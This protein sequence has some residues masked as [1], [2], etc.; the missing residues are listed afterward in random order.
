MT[1]FDREYRKVLEKIMKEGVEELNERTGHKTKS[2][3]GVSFVID[4]GFPLLTLR[5]VSV[6]FFVAEQ[7]WFLMGSRKPSEFLN[8]YVKAW[9]SFS[10]IDGV[11]T[12]AYGYRW[13][14]HFGRDQIEGLIKLLEKQPSSRH[15]VVI[16]WDPSDDGLDA[17]LGGRYKK[18]V[19]CPFCF[20]VNIIGGKLNIHNI[21]R[22]NDWILGGVMDVAGFALLQNILAARLG[23]EVGT[24]CHTVSNAHVYDIHYEAAAE[25]LKRKGDHEE[26][27]LSPK[28]N[29]YERAKKGDDSLVSEIMEQ[30]ESQYKPLESIGKL[31]MVL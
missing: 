31:G 30:F 23:V 15:G 24:Y 4:Q 20:V 21:I 25:I 11:V 1:Q 3:P 10:N 18:N 19:P 29:W 9:D 17:S 28:R 14:H 6:R 5:K 13:R 7:I 12:T 16:T 26:I 22:S 2:L 27:K 8:R